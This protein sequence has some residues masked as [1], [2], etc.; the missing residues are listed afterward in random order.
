[1]IEPKNFEKYLVKEG[2]ISEDL[3]LR[4]REEA[5]EKNLGVIDLLIQKGI[6]SEEN[7]Y[8]VLANYCGFK[9]IV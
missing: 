7:I 6:V 1:M 9:F 8:R 3:A 5:N 4:I 2:I